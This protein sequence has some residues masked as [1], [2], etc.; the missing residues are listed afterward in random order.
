VLTAPLVQTG[1]CHIAHEC[2]DDGYP[3]LPHANDLGERRVSGRVDTERRRVRD[4][5]R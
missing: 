1:V 2:M 5:A 3:I 4:E